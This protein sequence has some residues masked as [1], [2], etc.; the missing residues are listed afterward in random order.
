MFLE[1]PSL[2][3]RR[4]NKMSKRL[5]FDFTA[6]LDGVH[7]HSIAETFLSDSD[8]RDQPKSEREK[9]IQ[10]DTQCQDIRR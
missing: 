8:L 9:H 5:G 10:E 6:F 7:V 2:I 3:K 4:A 1:L